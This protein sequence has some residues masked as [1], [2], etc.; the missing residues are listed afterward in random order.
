MLL[1]IERLQAGELDEDDTA[2]ASAELQ[3]RL[4]LS[5]NSHCLDDTPDLPLCAQ[6]Q[7]STSNGHGCGQTLYKTASCFWETML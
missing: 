3:V 6:L 5:D 1:N 7:G 2:V 4:L